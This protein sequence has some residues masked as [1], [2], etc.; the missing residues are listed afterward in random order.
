MSYLLF[1]TSRLLHTFLFVHISLFF[2]VLP[3]NHAGADKIFFADLAL[4]FLTKYLLYGPILII[5]N[6][7]FPLLVFQRPIFFIQ[8]LLRYE[9]P[10]FLLPKKVIILIKIADILF[11]VEQH[12][13]MFSILKLHQCSIGLFGL[14]SLKFKLV[15]ELGLL[16]EILL[17]F[18]V[19]HFLLDLKLYLGLQMLSLDRAERLLSLHFLLLLFVVFLKVY[20]KCLFIILQ[21]LAEHSSWSL[22]FHD[23]LVF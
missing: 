7:F 22:L 15:N 10:R 23:D 1:Q 11:Q 9:E 20:I 2:V 3:Q 19:F 8:F 5:Q 16:A 21:R 18:L 17:Y 12:I 14:N 13:L 6:L 4:F